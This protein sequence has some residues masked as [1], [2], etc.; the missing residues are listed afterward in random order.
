MILVE[1]VD[2]DVEI[3]DTAV[4]VGHLRAEL[5]HA[6][7]VLH[8]LAGQIVQPVEILRIR[9]DRHLAAGILHGDHRLEK[10]PLAVLD[11]LAHRVQIGG[12]NHRGGENA[13]AVLAF[14]LA[15][16]LLEPFAQILQLRIETGEE[17]DLAAAVIEEIAHRG[18]LHRRVVGLAGAECL[19]GIFRTLD[20]RRDIEAG[21]RDGHQADGRQHGEAAADVVF[22][23]ESLVPFLVGK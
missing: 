21:Q 2:P 18:I 22:D 11:V 5:G 14:A 7:A 10:H 4:D 13:L 19:L 9:R 12:E 17:L 3:R 23:D 1:L 8:V 15:E 6:V 20:H 16:E